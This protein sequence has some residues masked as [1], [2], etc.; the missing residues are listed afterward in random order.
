LLL[1]LDIYDF[2]TNA[3]SFCDCD[4]VVLARW[5]KVVVTGLALYTVRGGAGV[6]V[7]GSRRVA[8]ESGVRWW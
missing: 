8:V 7:A 1:V 6:Q 5:F 3:A 4:V 2:V